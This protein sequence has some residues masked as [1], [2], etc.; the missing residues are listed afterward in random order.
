M[1]S[2]PV[3]TDVHHTALFVTDL[4]RSLEFYCGK[5][6]FE[7]VSR[8]DDWGGEFLDVICGGLE[9]ARVNIALVRAGGEIIELIQVL[10]PAGIPNDASSLPYGMARL[11]FE[12]A[13]IETAVAEL[14]SRGVEFMSEIITVAVEASPDDAPDEEQHYEGGRAIMFRDPDGIVLELQQPTKVGVIT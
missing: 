5:L 8:S 12:V 13:D 4:D 7:L 6:D 11:G 3:I 2:S 10:S 9:S 14:G 1:G